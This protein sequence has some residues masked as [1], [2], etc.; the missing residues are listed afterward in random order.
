[1][2]NVILSLFLFMFRKF[3]LIWEKIPTLKM[4]ITVDSEASL[5]R[6]KF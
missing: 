6:K 1:M 5:R 2:Q 4:E 3:M